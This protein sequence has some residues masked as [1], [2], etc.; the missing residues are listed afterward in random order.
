[1]SKEQVTLTARKRAQTISLHRLFLLFVDK[2]NIL[3]IKV[4]EFSNKSANFY[5]FIWLLVFG[6]LLPRNLFKILFNM[7]ISKNI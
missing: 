6:I 1:M 7:K 2:R 3:K 4:I 5:R